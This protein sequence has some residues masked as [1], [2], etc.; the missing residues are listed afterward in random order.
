MPCPWMKGPQ[1]EWLELTFMEL[2]QDCQLIY[3]QE[4]L[5]VTPRECIIRVERSLISVT[6]TVPTQH[7]SGKAAVGAVEQM[8]ESGSV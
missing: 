4:L 5:H 6:N 1:E 3:A 8:T 7:R 2:V